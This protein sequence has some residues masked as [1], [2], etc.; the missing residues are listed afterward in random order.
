MNPKPNLIKKPDYL[1]WEEMKLRCRVEKP[2][3]I[4]KPDYLIWEEMKLR[5]RVKN[6]CSFR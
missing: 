4:K 6:V 2:N 3:L 1:I 5:C